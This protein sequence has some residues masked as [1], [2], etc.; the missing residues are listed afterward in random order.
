M[1]RGTVMDKPKAEM[2]KVQQLRLR[3][4]LREA[5]META[6]RTGVVID[7]KDAELARLEILNDALDPV[8]ADIPQTVEIFDRGIARGEEPRLWIDMVAYVVSERE[9][10]V[11]RF[12]QDTRHG[13]RIIAETGSVDD[14][15]R[16]ITRYIARRIIERERALAA[17]EVGP[18]LRRHAA[19]RRKR[20]GVRNFLVG[21]LLG[22]AA[23]F[24]AAWIASAY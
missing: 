2:P 16:E 18:R 14:M 7:I 9:R 21:L 20:H 12:I 22:I 6:D 10:R 19:R 3:E 13:P 15:A 24:A 5:R 8:F 23:V 1:G 4:A 11:Y 17:D